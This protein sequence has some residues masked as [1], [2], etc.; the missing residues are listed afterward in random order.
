MD[1]LLRII[2]EGNLEYNTGKIENFSAEID[3]VAITAT[4]SPIKIVDKEY[5]PRIGDKLYFLPGVNIPRVKLKD[6]LVT[7]NISTVRNINDATVIFGG[8]NTN[9]KLVDSSWEYSLKTVDFKECLEA[10]KPSIDSYYYDKLATALEFYTMEKIIMNWNSYRFF[11][12]DAI[13]DFKNYV[14]NPGAVA[15][16]GGNNGFF[17]IVDSG[18]VDMLSVAISS[19]VINET[20]LI[21]QLNGDDAI[22]IDF[23]VFEK[24]SDM[25]K[26]SDADN[27]VLAMEIMANSNYAESL[28]YLEILFKEYG[29]I[30]QQNNTKNHVNFKS[31]L[32]YLNKSRYDFESNINSIVQS[33]INKQVLTVESLKIL[34]E[35][36][37]N[38]IESSG[39][40][41]F[42]KVKSI[43]LTEEL[44]EQLNT[45]F[46]HQ[47]RRDYVPIEIEESIVLP[48]EEEEKELT[49]L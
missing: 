45:N 3:Y 24:L 8:N 20:A 13:W 22:T 34:M 43:T 16:A 42:F 12:N 39:N 4:N 41:A 6:L 9:G 29:S 40:K 28:L 14:Q 30:M 18:Y 23:T 2:A 46:V 44:M 17:N 5:K 32:S 1:K 48:P 11:T 25:F 35:R 37:S 15:K 31:L 10:I 21:S 26:S 47:V 38:E 49:W 19:E 36:Y 7:Y 33:L 27:Y